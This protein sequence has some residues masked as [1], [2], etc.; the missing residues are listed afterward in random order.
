M[1]RIQHQACN[2]CLLDTTAAGIDF[3]SEGNCNFC[4]D[5]LAARKAFSPANPDQQR[6]RLEELVNRI[7]L[8][9]KGKDY[10]CVV[11]VSGG[12][13]S[14]WMLVQAITLGLRPLAVHMDNGWNSEL[15]QN[16]ISNLVRTLNVDLHTHVIDWEEYKSLMQA[17][18]DADVIDV[19]LLYDNAM[20]A[21]NH[22]MAVKYGLKYILVGYNSASEGITIPSNWNWFK[23]DK[24]NIR[25]I[26]KK[27]GNIR[28]KTFPAV[29]TIQ[30]F[31]NSYLRRISWTPLLE[32]V[33]YNKQAA[34]DQL[35]TEY[36][37]KPYPY[38]HYES[39]FTRFYQG[40]ILPNKFGV[41]KRKLHLG[42]LVVSGQMDKADAVQKLSEIPYPSHEALESD[43]HYFLKKMGWSES[44]L[45][46]YMARPEKNH[47]LYGSE[48]WLWDAVF[49]KGENRWIHR[50]IW[51]TLVSA[52]RLFRSPN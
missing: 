40:Y 6:Q 37:F 45:V 20:L 30:F 19:E 34:I 3:D 15:A 18:F 33:G 43:K 5:Y 9:G 24:K 50:A 38:K 12:A 48:K 7:K 29:G 31:M 41:D 13:D 4:T 14:S 23:Y 46:D 16:N 36:G 51:R 27:F 28:L 52:K 47:E 22:Q 2:R 21:V 44:Q 32:F 26:G 25:E 39:I 8:S 1:D 17:F 42:T 49:K 10:D 11:G 35:I